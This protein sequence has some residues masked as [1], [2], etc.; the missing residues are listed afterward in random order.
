MKRVG[1]GQRDHMT[2]GAPQ[3]NPEHHLNPALEPTVN[4]T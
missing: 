2:F 1:T 3:H 4:P